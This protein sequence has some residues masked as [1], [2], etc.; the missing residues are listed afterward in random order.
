MPDDND[1]AAKIKRLAQRLA[2]EASTIGLTLHGFAFSPN[3]D[4]SGPDTVQAAFTLD[5]LPGDEPADEKA[6]IDAALAEIERGML[7]DAEAN[8]VT[9][10]RNALDDLQRRLAEGGDILGDDD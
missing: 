10:T 9:E 5:S 4:G 8:K 7:R 6:A 3:L 1:P 2:E